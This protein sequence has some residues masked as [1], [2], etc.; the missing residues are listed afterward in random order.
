MG[1]NPKKGKNEK[2]PGR[3]SPPS[4]PAFHQYDPNGPK[5]APL[6]DPDGRPD[7]RPNGWPVGR[8][9]GK[10][11]RVYFPQNGYYS[12]NIISNNFGGK[13][14]GKKRKDG[15]RNLKK[16]K[17]KKES[18]RNS[19]FHQYDSNEPKIVSNGPL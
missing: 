11:R 18:G 4:Q 15:G 14:L 17:N 1:K 19:A 16:E 2:E 13:K 5:I 9:V 10:A 6:L 7:G 3:N 8:P 12:S